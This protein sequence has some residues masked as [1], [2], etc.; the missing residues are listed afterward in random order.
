[1]PF[2]HS[3]WHPGL[4]TLFID[5]FVREIGLSHLLHRLNDGPTRQGFFI[6]RELEVLRGRALSIFSLANFGDFDI[7]ARPQANIGNQGSGAVGGPKEAPPDSGITKRPYGDKSGG[8]LWGVEKSVKQ[9]S[10]LKIQ[11][12]EEQRTAEVT[13]I[14]T[15]AC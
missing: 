6:A 5:F 13:V 2:A 1:M 14:A 9:S 3:F 8:R 7:P 15:L 10:S 4:P 12:V 11:Q